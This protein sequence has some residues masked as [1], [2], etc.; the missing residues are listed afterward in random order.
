M[1]ANPSDNLI[2]KH[3]QLTSVKF[4]E[5]ISN[6]LDRLTKYS[7]TLKEDR[8]TEVNSEQLRNCFTINFAG[9]F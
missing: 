1:N 3:L 4:I 5:N 7:A 2:K 9:L 6:I 8:G